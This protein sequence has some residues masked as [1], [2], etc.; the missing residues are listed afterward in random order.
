V[1]WLR[2]VAIAIGNALR[3]EVSLQEQE[4]Q[5]L[6]RSLQ[7]WSAHTDIVVSESVAWALEN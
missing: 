7:H 3:A 1:R 4:Q 2:N 5:A 6:R